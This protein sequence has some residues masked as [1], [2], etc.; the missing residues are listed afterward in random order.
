VTGLVGVDGVH[1]GYTESHRVYAMALRS[2]HTDGY[3]VEET[4]DFFLR[5]HGTEGDCSCRNHWSDFH[6]PT[7]WSY[8]GRRSD[9]RSVVGDPMVWSYLEMGSRRGLEKA[10]N[11]AWRMVGNLY[12]FAPGGPNSKLQSE[13]MAN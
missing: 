6:A 12:T 9:G 7:T 8:L 2:E 4:W 5:N 11:A 3:G 13:C 10:D 1:G